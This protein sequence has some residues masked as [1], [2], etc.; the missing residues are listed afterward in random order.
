MI[1]KIKDW[2]DGS[3]NEEVIKVTSVEPTESEKRLNRLL[4]NI[5]KKALDRK[6]IRVGGEMYLPSVYKI[7]LSSEDFSTLLDSE[8]KFLEKKLKEIILQ[9]A[10][11]L[12]G[13]SKLTT[14]K[15][16]VK[17]YEDGTL[18]SDE[19]EVKTTDNLQ[20]TIELGKFD[21]NP[22][23][24]TFVSNSWL[25]PTVKFE[26]GEKTWELPQ[27]N[28]Q[29]DDDGTIDAP[30]YTTGTIDADDVV[31]L[32]PLYY[33]EIWEN[34]KM[35]E[36]FPILKKQVTIGR[37]TKNKP[38]NIRLKTDDK[39]ISSLHASIKFNSESDITVQALH[40]NITKV[41]KTVISDGKPDFPTETKLNRGDEIQIFD[42]KIKLRFI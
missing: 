9:K 6:I 27:P 13:E 15:I 5:K 33:L 38:A 3:E 35:I 17:I 12:A 37:D 2:I 18:S 14:E 4:E 42:F 20:D 32:D 36:E 28:P 25:P 30:T 41:G 31:D 26:T 11:E 23:N 24:K 34:D 22:I 7:Y 19:V 16:E 8:K 29:K 40:K 1:K 39:Q 21:Y 10:L